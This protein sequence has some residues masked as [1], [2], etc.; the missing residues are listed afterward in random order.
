MSQGNNSVFY[1]CPKKEMT[2]LS[3]LCFFFC[4]RIM[5]KQNLRPPKVGECGPLWGALGLL[6]WAKILGLLHHHFL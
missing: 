4:R 2:S 6:W 1:S 3:G 5:T